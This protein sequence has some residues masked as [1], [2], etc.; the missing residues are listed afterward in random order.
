MKFSHSRCLRHVEDAWLEQHP[1]NSGSPRWCSHERKQLQ[2]TFTIG[3][4]QSLVHISA[5]TRGAI[6]K[7][8]REAA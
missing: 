4:A 3:L 5:E 6:K 7:I 8:G 1:T 2:R